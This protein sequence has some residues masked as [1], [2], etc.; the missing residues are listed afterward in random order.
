MRS[1]QRRFERNALLNPHLSSYTNFA[2]AVRWQKFSRSTI[3]EWFN[4]LIDENDYEQADRNSLIRELTK[5]SEE[6]E[7]QA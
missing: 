5:L 1:I 2:R 3:S 7:F 4:K 6:T